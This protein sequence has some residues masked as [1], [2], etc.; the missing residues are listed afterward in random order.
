MVTTYCTSDDVANLLQ[1]PVFDTATMPTKIMVDK[2]INQQEARIDSKLNTGWRE[3]TESDL[4]ITAT[5]EY[6]RNG[7]RYDLPNYEI[8]AIT[9]LEVWNGSTYD[10]L[11][12]TGTEGRAADYWVDKNLGV[13]YVRRG[14][15]GR[16]EKNIKV[17]YTHGGTVV[18]L[19]IEDLCS[20]MTAVKVLNQYEQVIQW[21]EDGG[22]TG[23]NNMSRITELRKDIKSIFNSYSN[24]STI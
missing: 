10:D 4:Y 11:V 7:T 8:R 3:L 9:K 2:L 12:V 13:L 19:D 17:S 24:I 15:Y 20:M 22:N 14:V 23:N 5:N 18:P 16:R 21:S 6:D 1:I